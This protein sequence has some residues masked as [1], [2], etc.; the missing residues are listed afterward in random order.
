MGNPAFRTNA[1]RF[2][3]WRYADPRG[4]DVTFREIGEAIG[5]HP[6]AVSDVCR[7]NNWSSRV[8]SETMDHAHPG[9]SPT[10]LARDIGEATQRNTA[11]G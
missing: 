1:R 4:W 9:E 7:R 3:V 11:H 10:A 8:R 5:L 6:R 2:A